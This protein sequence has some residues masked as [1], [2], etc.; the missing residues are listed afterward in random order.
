MGCTTILVGK[1]ATYDGSTAPDILQR[2]SL[3]WFLQSSSRKPIIP[4]SLM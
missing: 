1:K 2:R 3:Q 4:Y